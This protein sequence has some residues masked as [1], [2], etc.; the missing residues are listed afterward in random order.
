MEKPNPFDMTRIV[1]MANRF[2]EELIKVPADQRWQMVKQNVTDS[3]LVFAV[4]QE[5]TAK[6]GV[7]YEI[8]KGQALL[9]KIFRSKKTQSI[10]VAAIPCI[11][12]A[13]AKAVLMVAGER[14][15]LLP[16]VG[17]SKD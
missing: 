17:D 1:E 14:V 7:G 2:Q 12:K 6:N 5:R 9:R 13:Q 4:W 8:I 11:E 10:C 15:W 3:D 16:E